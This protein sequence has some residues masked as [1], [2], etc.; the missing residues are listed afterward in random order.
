MTA[1]S[2]PDL[3]PNLLDVLV[4][5]AGFGGMYALHR[6]RSAGYSVVVLEAGGDVGGTWYW[7]RYPGARCDVESM[8]YSF[9]FDDDLQQEWSWSKRYAEQPEILEYASH[10]A[11]RFDLRRDIRFN[12][13]V[14]LAAYDEE[15][16]HWRVET[17]DGRTFIARFV[18][19]ATG[20]LSTPKLPEIP[21][22]ETFKGACHHT[23][24]W[25]HDG[26]D[27]SGKRVGLFGTGATGMQAVPVIARDAEELVVFQRTANFSVP[28]HNRSLSEEEE[29]DWKARYA[30]WRE[31]ERSTHSGF[32]NEG[33][34]PAFD[35]LT[36][37]ER[38]EVLEHRWQHGGL[39]M[40]NVFSDL[41]T[42]RAANDATI[43]FLH[44]KIR[45]TV[46]D[47][48]T[49]ELLCPTTHPVGAK[50]LCVDSGYFEAFNL[51]N[52]KLVDIA[53]HPVERITPD[54]LIQNGREMAFDCLVFATGFDAMTGTLLRIDIRGRDGRTL[55]D[56]WQAGP[57]SYLGLA[58]EGFP[59]LFT[60]TGPGSPSVLSHVIMAIEQ[61][62]NWI[63]DCLDFMS[64][65]GLTRIEATSEAESGWVNHV[66][67]VADGTF[68]LEADSWYMGANVP[69]KPRVFMPYTGGAHKYRARCDEVA[70]A[71]Y[72]GFV[73]NRES[74]SELP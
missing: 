16:G 66:R 46:K 51:P 20:T 53:T 17:D 50:R 38:E 63:A 43:K 14:A 29:A 19:M 28:A 15:T 59:N 49:A 39:L 10:V 56:K 35:P 54:G 40:W 5:G 67:D 8:S 34:H 37:E 42:N 3:Q 44:R 25:P 36:D 45:E 23:G 12:T 74:E 52:V 30:Y 2:E 33:G 24:A 27:F 72:E 26:V 70:A 6:L 64:R 62:V 7:N 58:L 48:E 55:R 18:I 65:N 9:S 21:G 57:V 68:F 41:M 32:H 61:H 11:D 1:A 22:I 69:G 71:G 4:V 73:L 60:I 31:R 47:P 13:R